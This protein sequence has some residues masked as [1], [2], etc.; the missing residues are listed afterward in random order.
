MNKFL[1][2][3]ICFFTFAF[4]ADFNMKTYETTLISVENGYGT[5]TD[6][7]DI[8]IGSSGI[9]SHT[10]L[11]GESSII[12]RAVV[13]EKNG[14][15]AKVRFEVF[16]MLAQKALP[17]PKILPQSGD[18]IVLNFLYSRSLLITP[19]K[20]I[21]DQIKLAFPNIDF[22]DPDVNA[23]YLSSEFKP[24][25]GRDEFRKM[26]ADN[27]AGLIFFALN[28]KGV[29]ADCGSFKTLKTFKT[30]GINSYTLPFYS[31]VEGISTMI[32]DFKNG[33]INDYD[34]YYR[35]LLGEE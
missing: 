35:Y 14:A 34:E 15:N 2:I 27:A 30:G 20:E 33:Q 7:P 6:S 4:S 1:L 16:S 13:T 28:G 9:I 10:F 26:C 25:P 24:N 8:V 18:K 29:F 19:N 32:W 5:V 23:A 12:A 21:Y 17:L 3:F 22:V 11:N 31:H